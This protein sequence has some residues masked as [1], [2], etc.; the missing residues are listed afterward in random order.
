[1]TI[2][3]SENS[4]ESIISHCGSTSTNTDTVVDDT[5][6]IAME[7]K[8]QDTHKI[9]VNTIKKDLKQEI[10]EPT[11]KKKDDFEF[12]DSLSDDDLP[13]GELRPSKRARRDK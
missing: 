5:A 13:I 10:T 2:C 6:A 9:E 3:D 4:S 7:A 11:T 1:M 12:H 8:I